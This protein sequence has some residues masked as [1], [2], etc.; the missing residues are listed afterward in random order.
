MLY[1]AFLWVINVTK[2][3]LECGQFYNRYGAI[4]ALVVSA[5]PKCAC[6]V[7]G[8]VIPLNYFCPLKGFCS[9]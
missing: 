3:G 9:F 2:K 8:L 7:V 6:Y 1:S 4:F 5:N